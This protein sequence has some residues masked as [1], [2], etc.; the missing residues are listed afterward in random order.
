M[1]RS[2]AFAL[3]L[4]LVLG[5]PATAQN[6]PDKPIRFYVG[7]PPGGSTDLISR[8][9]GQKL[10]DRLK[11]P[12]VVEQKVG[13]TGL[14]ANDAVAKSPPD[15]YT[16]VLLTGGHPG[17]AA[18]MKKLPYDPVA[19]FG[20]VS[21]VI[22]YP[23]VISVAPESSIKSFAELVA[24][25]KSAPGRISFS[26][27]GPGS[28]HHLL[29]EWL[30]IEAGTT[31]LHVPFKGAAPAYTELLGGRIDIL[32]ETAT[33]SFPQIRGGKLRPLA[34]SSAGR[35][36]LMPEVQTVAEVLPGVEFSSWLGVAVAP[37]TPRPVI[38]RLNRELGA[39]LAEED[40]KQRFAGFG[41][42][43]AASTPE[44]MKSRVEREIA[45][46]NRV[47]ESRKIERQ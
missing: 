24:R 33:F 25:A 43:P 29:G 42:V 37:G 17:T 21:T 41:G 18:V 26:S 8:L 14:I 15:G 7:F 1:R 20:M 38:E 27:A 11:Q 31:M 9:L 40:V 45:R 34:L 4:L 2:V 6:Y 23:M 13:G 19:D 46:W 22:E 39:I 47:V 10:S 5:A 3:L 36:P 12:V 44:A 28:L 16:M 32:I 35:Y 30:S